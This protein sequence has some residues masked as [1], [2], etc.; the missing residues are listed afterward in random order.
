MGLH[1]KYGLRKVINACGKLTRLTG[2]V[3]LPA[4]AEAAREAGLE[5]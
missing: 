2:S 5:F 4:V 3:V 1:Q